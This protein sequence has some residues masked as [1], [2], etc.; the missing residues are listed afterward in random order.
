[1]RTS[2][3]T[4]FAGNAADDDDVPEPGGHASLSRAYKCLCRSDLKLN[5]IP[6]PKKLQRSVVGFVSSAAHGVLQH[7][8]IVSQIHRAERG[9]QDA[10]IGFSSG[11]MRCMSMHKWIHLPA[12]I[13]PPS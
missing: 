3:T 1:M 10:D 8:D 2:L 13:D 6:I 9:Y 5:R 4:S 12:I 11:N 7:D